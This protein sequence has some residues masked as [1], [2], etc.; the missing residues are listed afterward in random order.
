M[1]ISNDERATNG[2][3]KDYWNIFGEIMVDDRIEENINEIAR[4]LFDEK[5]RSS[6]QP[7]FPNAAKDLFSALI[8]HLVRN[9]DFE[10][11]R[12]MCL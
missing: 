10:S 6:S 3:D 7:F 11:R 5:I 12:N 1:V 4:T 2:Y 8:T 9:D